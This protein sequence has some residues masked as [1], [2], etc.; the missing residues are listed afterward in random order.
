MNELIKIQTKG[1]KQLVSARELYKGLGLSGR[2]SRWANNNL[3]LF[4]ENEDFYKCTSSTVVNNGAVRELDD[5][6]L[7]IE[8][9]KQLAMMARTEKS[10]LYRAYF[11]QLEKNWNSPDMVMHR[12]LE[13]SNQRVKQL[14][15]KNQKLLEENFQQKAENQKLIETNIKQAE[16]IE[17]DKD[18]VLFSRAIRTADRAISIRELSVLLTQNGFKIGQ[19][20]LF[21]LLRQT[22][23][24]SSMKSTWNLPN[25]ARVK[26]GYF[27]V[28]HKVSY[29]G[30]PYRQTLVTVKGQK[31]IIN[32]ALRGKF[33]DTYNKIVTVGASHEY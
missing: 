26:S 4:V 30:V 11:L 15:L 24:L 7:T 1:D 9:A 25:I 28:V 8:T 22:K 5:Y 32:K 2:F 13:F 19:H 10:K 20:Q 27:R 18:D 21:A 12:A 31:H 16:K 29:E 23:Y 17:K 6:L 33:D 14:Q 3:E